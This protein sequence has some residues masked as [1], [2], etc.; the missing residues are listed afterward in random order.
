MD[1]DIRERAVVERHQLVEGAALRTMLGE[2]GSRRDKQVYQG[3]DSCSRTVMV[4]RT[5]RMLRRI[6]LSKR[7]QSSH[8]NGSITDPCSNGMHA[9]QQQ[10]HANRNPAVLR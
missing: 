4:R 1:A 9:L 2:R 8:A 5:N 6:P 7:S 3:H 10:E